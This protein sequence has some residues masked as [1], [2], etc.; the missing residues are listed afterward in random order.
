MFLLKEDAF[1]KLLM[2][3]KKFS[4]DLPMLKFLMTVRPS[5]GTFMLSLYCALFCISVGV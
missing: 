3:H 1:A 4:G 2:L 5:L